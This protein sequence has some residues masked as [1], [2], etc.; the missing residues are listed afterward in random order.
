LKN[1]DD[2]GKKNQLN[3]I[4]RFKRIFLEKDSFIMKGL[5]T[6]TFK[7]VRAKCKEHYKTM[8]EKLYAE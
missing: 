7:I 8:I 1:L 6:P 5:T 2:Y 3:G 4:E